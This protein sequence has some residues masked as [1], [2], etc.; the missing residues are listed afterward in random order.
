MVLTDL[1]DE[2][3]LLWMDQNTINHHTFI[4]RAEA[5][6]FLEDFL[7][8]RIEASEGV[9][10]S[11]ARVAKRRKL[12]GQLA[13]ARNPAG[14][15]AFEEQLESLEGLVDPSEIRQMRA[16]YLLRQFVDSPFAP[17]WRPAPEG[18]YA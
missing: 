1:R 18:M 7:A 16:E 6:G 15:A 8:R 5:V 17:S 13:A 4:S 2:L 14:G 12:G 10:P 11:A 3:H 9:H